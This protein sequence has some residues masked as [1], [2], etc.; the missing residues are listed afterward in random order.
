VYIPGTVADGKDTDPE[1]LG[2]RLTG[3]IDPDEIAQLT[4][5]QTAPRTVFYLDK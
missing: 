5:Q 4:A 3:G 1:D 2:F